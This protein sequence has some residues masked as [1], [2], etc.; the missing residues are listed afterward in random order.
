M[1]VQEV[2]RKFGEIVAVCEGLEAANRLHSGFVAKIGEDEVVYL[3]PMPPT[4]ADGENPPDLRAAAKLFLTNIQTARHFLG[5]WFDLDSHSWKR[6][7]DWE[8]C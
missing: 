4:V 5:Q 8:K 2:E 3:E 1:D 7:R 6:F